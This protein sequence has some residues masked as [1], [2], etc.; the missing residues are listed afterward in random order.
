MWLLDG[1]TA[2]LQMD[3]F[4]AELN[5]LRPDLGMTE[6]RVGLGATSPI[7]ID[8]GKLLQVHRPGG[9]A[10]EAGPPSERVSESYV[11]GADLVARYAASDKNAVR[12]QI[13]WRELNK[14][15]FERAGVELIVSVETSLLDSDPSTKVTSVLPAEETLVLGRA[16]SDR[17]EKL[18]EAGGDH[19]S[20]PGGGPQVLLVRLPGCPFSYLEMVAPTDA[21]DIR[22]SF[23]APSSGV[24]RVNYLFFGERIE[25]GVIR[26]SC[27]RGCFIP[28]DNDEAAAAHLYHDFAASEP[29]LTV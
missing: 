10:T 15:R 26:R 14:G 11:R 1:T 17:F 19:A 2:K 23:E 5:L 28:R 7:S 22:V 13:Y 20:A 12:P 8:S 27:L 24:L 3:S 21:D 16:Q 4:T 9:S 18:D 29:P 6:L 25:K